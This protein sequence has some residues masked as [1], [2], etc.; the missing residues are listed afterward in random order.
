MNSSPA[1]KDLEVTGDGR[2][3][4]SQQCALLVN[5]ADYVL[6]CVNIMVSRLREV[7]SFLYLVLF[8]NPHLYADM[9]P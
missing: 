9:G 1:E 8:M 7:I 5:K 4:K 3:N 2:L 6:C